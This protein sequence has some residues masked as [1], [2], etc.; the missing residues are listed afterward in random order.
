MAGVYVM[1][2]LINTIFLIGLF[3]VASAAHAQVYQWKDSDSRT[4]RFSNTAPQWYGNTQSE[5]R[6]PRVQ[7]FYYGVLVDD[8]NLSFEVRQGMR[9]QTPIGRYLPRLISPGSQQTRR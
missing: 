1:K 3:A 2:R 6:G 9:S 8:T 4:T 7:V 5:S